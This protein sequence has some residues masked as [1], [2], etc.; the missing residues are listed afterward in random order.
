MSGLALPDYLPV[1]QQLARAIAERGRALGFD[2]KDV[3]TLCFYH[4]ADALMRYEVSL[5]LIHLAGYLLLGSAVV[6]GKR[7]ELSIDDVFVRRTIG[8]L[9]GAQGIRADGPRFLDEYIGKLKARLFHEVWAAFEDALRQ[10][11]SGVVPLELQ[12]E[13][14]ADERGRYVKPPAEVHVGIPRIWKRLSDLTKTHGVT[15]KAERRRHAAVV[16]F[17]AATRNTIH[18]NTFYA[19]PEKTLTLNEESIRLVPGEPTDFLTPGNVLLLVSELETAFAFLCTN[20]KHESRILGPYSAR[21]WQRDWPPI[22][23][24][25]VDGRP[26]NAAGASRGFENGRRW[27]QSVNALMS[28]LARSV[29]AIFSCR[30]G[31]TGT[32]R[33]QT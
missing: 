20:I 28:A 26:H 11:Y 5:S 31:A 18:S 13:D 22:V 30:R 2:P 6:R 9:F 25:P 15:T 12:R 23:F 24:T 33:S 10:L 32:R 17:L 21:D 4:V 14:E 19:G 1:I 3:R 7:G 8:G 27:H 29:R 16:D